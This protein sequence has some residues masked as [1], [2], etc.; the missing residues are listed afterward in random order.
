MLYC[1]TDNIMEIVGTETCHFFSQKQ[2]TQMNIQ[3]WEHTSEYSKLIEQPFSRPQSVCAVCLNLRFFKI[4]LKFSAALKKFS[5]INFTTLKGKSNANRHL[6]VYTIIYKEK[7][8]YCSGRS[9]QTSTVYTCRKW[10]TLWHWS[11]N[12]WPG[13]R[14]EKLIVFV[15]GG[16]FQ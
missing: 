10:N 6:N 4:A 15:A 14:P 9:C 8:E 7:T 5:I 12:C 3:S 1:H 13:Y 2:I 16:T 11:T